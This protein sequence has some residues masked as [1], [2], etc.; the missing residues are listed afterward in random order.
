MLPLKAFCFSSTQKKIKLNQTFFS[1][2]LLSFPI[3]INRLIHI[4]TLLSY[5]TQHNSTAI[6]SWPEILHFKSYLSGAA[7][8]V[9]C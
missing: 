2:V 7:S 3:I 5:L 6:K 9:A 8:V 4:I 1:Q